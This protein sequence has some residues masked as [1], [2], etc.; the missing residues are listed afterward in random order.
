MKE[1][2]SEYIDMVESPVKVSKYVNSFHVFRASIMVSFLL[3]VL[4]KY[5]KS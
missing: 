5:G 1:F 3:E 4:S 2:F